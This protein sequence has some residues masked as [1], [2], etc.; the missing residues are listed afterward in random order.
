MIRRYLA[1][2]FLGLAVVTTASAH[3]AFLIPDGAD[4]GKAVFS[5]TLK[6]D[7]QGVPVEKLAKTTLHV[8]VDGKTETLKWT[9]DKTGNCYTFDL[10]GTGTRLVYGAT[11]YGIFQRG[12]AKPMW[13]KY[14]PK[15]IY[16]PLPAAEQATL[17]AKVP[18]EIVPIMAQQNATISLNADGTKPALPADS[19][20]PEFS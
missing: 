5:D 6:P 18:V 8:V 12:D 20:L 19:R 15:G 3:F 11:D 16:G 17:G 13:L 1:A 14:Y 9:H 2:C 4:K 7:A 10:P